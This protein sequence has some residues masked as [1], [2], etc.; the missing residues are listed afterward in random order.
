[1]HPPMNGLE[2]RSIYTSI[3][4]GVHQTHFGSPMEEPFVSRL[5]QIIESGTIAKV[6]AHMYFLCPSYED[7]CLHARI[8]CD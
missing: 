6:S 5:L 7:K 2:K 4:Y 3:N 8:E 1:M